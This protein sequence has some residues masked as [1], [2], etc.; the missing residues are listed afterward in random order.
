M[1]TKF[2]L[3]LCLVAMPLALSGCDSGGKDQVGTGM[4]EPPPDVKARI[5]EENKKRQQ[6]MD[7]QRANPTPIPEG[8]NQSLPP[9]GG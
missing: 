6:M 7:Q 8:S 5:E 9:A 1:R 2:L 3:C 4:K